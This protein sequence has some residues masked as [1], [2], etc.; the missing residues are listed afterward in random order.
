MS[1]IA[2]I[3]VRRYAMKVSLL[4]CGAFAAGLQWV[5]C[6][7][8]GHAGSNAGVVQQVLVPAEPDLSIAPRLKEVK[9]A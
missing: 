2:S 9:K 4:L 7:V 3:D 6:L 1:D 5:T 8:S